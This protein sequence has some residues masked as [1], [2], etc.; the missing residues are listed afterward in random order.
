MSQTLEICEV[1]N[2]KV[3][4]SNSKKYENEAAILS[5]V[6][7]IN[8]N[9]FHERLRKDD[10][11]I[12]AVDVDKLMLHNPSSNLDHVLTD[13]SSFIGCEKNEISY[14]TNLSI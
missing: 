11:L 3:N 9:Q 6:F 10:N 1:S 7:L 13:V 2:Y 8:D 5:D 12:L 4:Y 14:T